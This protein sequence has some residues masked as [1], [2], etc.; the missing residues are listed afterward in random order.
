M[1]KLLLPILLLF[2]IPSFSQPVLTGA[3]SNPVVGELFYRHVVDTAGVKLG[4]SGPGSVWNYGGLTVIK[5]DTV[6]VVTCSS[7]PYCDS[8]PTSSIAFQFSPADVSYGIANSAFTMGVGGHSD[9]VGYS[10]MLR[11]D[12]AMIYPV[13]YP[14]SWSDTSIE[15]YDTTYASSHLFRSGSRNV[16]G[17]GTLILPSGTFTNVMRIHDV[18]YL[19]DSN[20]T[21]S[22][23][24]VYYHRTDGYSW[25]VPGFHF[26][27]L[28]MEVDNDVM[29]G[30]IQDIF[31][32]VYYT[33]SGLASLSV[34]RDQIPDVQVYPNPVKDVIHINNLQSAAAYRIVNVVG[35]VLQQGM[36]DEHNSMLPV[37]YLVPGMYTLVLEDAHTGE[38]TTRKI[39][40][41]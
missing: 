33:G 14:M 3:N 36:V 12:T 9:A 17:Y 2:C 26:P 32:V 16:D 5:N 20:Y 18:V 40:K 11:M 19:T 28:T 41:E 6:N 10:K 38:R 37:K 4:A 31:F 7:T 23:L 8:F 21:G 1:K 22:S 34:A 25:Y 35:M 27:L 13:S 24:H 29:T 39:V 30:A 15:V